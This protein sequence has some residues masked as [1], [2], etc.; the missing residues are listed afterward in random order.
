MTKKPLKHQYYDRGGRFLPETITLTHTLVG[1]RNI[2]TCPS[3]LF[4][5][6]Q[7]VQ[8]ISR[9]S[10]PSTPCPSPRRRSWQRTESSTGELLH[11]AMHTCERKAY[12][13]LWPLKDR[14]FPLRL[15]TNLIHFLPTLIK[16][17]LQLHSRGVPRSLVLNFAE[18]CKKEIPSALQI[19]IELLVLKQ[20]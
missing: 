2:L 10:P 6:S 9:E 11:L 18:L 20:T 12:Q 4:W 8:A 5:N 16:P 15:I 14:H 3:P 17:R 1:G 7:P 19:S 13:H